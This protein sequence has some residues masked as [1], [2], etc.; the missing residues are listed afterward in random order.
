MSE[1]RASER[2]E[3]TEPVR[4]VLSMMCFEC[5]PLANCYRIDGHAIKTRAEDEQSFVLHRFLNIALEHGERWRE[6][7]GEELKGI[8]ARAKEREVAE[9]ARAALWTVER[10]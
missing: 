9:K 6:V 2:I 1:H 5:G 7:V 10:T 4:E 8:T 3:M